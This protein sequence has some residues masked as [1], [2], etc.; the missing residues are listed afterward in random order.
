MRDS[1][2]VQPWESDPECPGSVERS[3][4]EFRVPFSGEHVVC[5]PLSSGLGVG[6]PGSQRPVRLPSSAGI[7]LQPTSNFEKLPYFPL[8][9]ARVGALGA[10]WLGLGP[11]PSP[12]PHHPALPSGQT[13][14]GD[15]LVPRGTLPAWPQVSVCACV[16]GGSLGQRSAVA[17]ATRGWGSQCITAYRTQG[18]RPTPSGRAWGS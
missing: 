10:S 6:T 5:P 16:A 3:L 8:L 4:D 15:S 11:I 14:V 2:T 12:L 13:L 7:R 17:R 9:S 1:P 18:R